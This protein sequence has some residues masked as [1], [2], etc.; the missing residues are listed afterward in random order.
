MN[1]NWL[2]FAAIIALLEWIAVERQ[3]RPLEYFAKPGAILALIIWLWQASGFQGYTLWLSLGLMLSLAGDVIL[4]LPGDP[5]IPG[6]VAFLLAHIAYIIGFNASPPPVNLP[7]FVILLAVFLAVIPIYRGIAA[8][9]HTSGQTSLRLP[10]LAYAIVI[11]LMLLSALL[12][13]VRP[14]WQPATALMAGVGALSFFISDSILAWARF[15]APLPHGRLIVMVT[16]HIGQALIVLGCT[17]HYL[18]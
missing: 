7:A 18:A 17:L 5:L 1:Y 15:V 9:L 8:G 13:L 16:Y 14:E 6:L 12:T 10:V 3:V 11:S 2:A 4:L